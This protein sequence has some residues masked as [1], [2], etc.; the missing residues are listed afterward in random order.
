MANSLF[1]YANPESLYRDLDT[2]TIY[3][4]AFFLYT[5]LIRSMSK[6]RLSLLGLRSSSTVESC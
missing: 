4:P 1:R 6:N 2:H 5:K 3:V